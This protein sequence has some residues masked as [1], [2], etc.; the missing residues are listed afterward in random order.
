MNDW[1]QS[2]LAGKIAAMRG[3][4][5]GRRSFDG[6]KKVAFER[7]LQYAEQRGRTIVLVLPVS[8]AYKKAFLPPDTARKLEEALSSLRRAA[9]RAEWVRIDKLPHLS[10]PD[11]FCDL[12]HLNTAGKQIATNAFRS[13]LEQATTSP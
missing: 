10:S 8:P 9:P 11:E 13:W 4:F 2:K 5:Q 12:D 6:A 7:M 1:S 3:S